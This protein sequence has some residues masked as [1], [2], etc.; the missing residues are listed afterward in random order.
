MRK[1]NKNLNA[2]V[3]SY[4]FI[5]ISVELLNSNTASM[6]SL[7]T[8]K[9]YL[10]CPPL[11]VGNVETTQKN[12]LTYKRR[13][14]TL[15]RKDSYNAVTGGNDNLKNIDAEQIEA[16]SCGNQLKKMDQNDRRQETKHL[17]GNVIEKGVNN[18]LVKIQ[19][20]ITV[21]SKATAERKNRSEL[22]RTTGEQG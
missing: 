11:C 16:N 21:E 22:R 7:K 1:N 9:K 8:C 15:S 12:Y 20:T 18:W 17:Q 14:Q 13:Y 5:S 10:N 6:T 4:L 2:L 3:V 19:C